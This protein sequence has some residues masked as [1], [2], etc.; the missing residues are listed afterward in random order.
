M[1]TMMFG[2]HNSVHKAYL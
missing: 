1:D 2:I